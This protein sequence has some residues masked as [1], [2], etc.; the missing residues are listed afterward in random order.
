MIPAWLFWDHKDLRTLVT[1]I[2]PLEK[3]DRRP[4]EPLSEEEIRKLKDLVKSYRVRPEQLQALR[5]ALM[6]YEGTHSFHN[7]TNKLTSKDASAT[8]YIVSFNVEDPMIF[9][10]GMQWIPTQVIGQSFLIH[11]IRKMVSVAVDSARLDLPD[12][13]TTALSKE[14]KIRSDLAPAQGL[15]LEM[16]FYDGYNQRLQPQQKASGVEELNWNNEETDAY[17]RWKAFRNGV[18]MD[19]IVKE[20]ARENNFIQ[21]WYNHEFYFDYTTHYGLSKDEGS[22]VE[23]T[24]AKDCE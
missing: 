5:S 8:R 17:K 1:K 4:G 16:S 15:F 23:D 22:A 24:A 19:H 10:G 14:S 7:F 9:D 11:Q 6:Q 18:L 21:H 20:E 12:L 13:I 3:E 2:A